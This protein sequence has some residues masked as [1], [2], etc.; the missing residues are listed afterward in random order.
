MS[1]ISVALL[2]I[3]GTVASVTGVVLYVFNGTR[4]LM[5]EMNKTQREMHE[6]LKKIVTLIEGVPE[7][8]AKA[9]KP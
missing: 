1:D 7:R 9:L 3:F 6:T 8:T 2:T 4:N 5:K